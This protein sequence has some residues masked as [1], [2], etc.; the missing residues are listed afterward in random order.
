MAPISV[1]VLM[2]RRCARL[3][4]ASRATS[5]RRRRS[6]SITSAARVSRLSPKPCAMAASVR[7]EQGATTMALQR[8]E[9]LAMEAPTAFTSCT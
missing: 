4:G 7:M 9:P 8:N 6:F 2:L 3:S 5:T 1:T